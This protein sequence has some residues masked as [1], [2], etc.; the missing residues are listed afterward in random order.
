MQLYRFG[1]FVC[2]VFFNTF[3]RLEVSGTENVPEQGAVILASNHISTLDPPL[4]GTPLK[5]VVRFMAKEELFK[6]PVLGTII[7]NVGAFPVKRG[8][9]SKESIRH[10]LQLLKEGGVMGIFPEGT[11][12][13]GMGKKGAASLALRS[14]AVVIPVGIIGNYKMF[15]KI[16]IVYGKPVDLSAYRES[17]SSDSLE[18]A[19][20]HIMSSIRELL[21][22]RK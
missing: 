22:A 16:K 8:G 14:G 20:E 3:F 11:R 19:T 18:Q 4:V 21:T 10:A 17:T 9:V 12:G 13:G 15:S 6:V 2:R 7:R 1:R 5:R